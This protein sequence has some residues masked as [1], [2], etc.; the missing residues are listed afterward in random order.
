MRKLILFLFLFLNW[1]ANNHSAFGVS[2]Y[3]YPVEIIQPDG[4]KIILIQRGDEHVKWAQTVDGYSVMRNSKGIYE[5][6]V[7]SNANDMIP[8]G[9]P[10]KNESDR[11]LK[12]N[13]YLSKT[14]K[15]LGYSKSQVGMMKSISN[16]Y[17]KSAFKAFPTSGARKLVCLLIG[18]TDKAFTKTKTDFENLFNQ[19][20]YVADGA[21]GSVYDFYKENSYGK[22]DLTVTVAGPFTAAHDMA[23]Y[24]ANNA[25]GDDVN[26]GALVTEAINLANPFVNYADFDND[27]D[28][29]VDGIYV[30]YAGYGEE[31]AGVSANAIWAHSSAV[32]TVVLDGKSISVYSCSAELRG[33][34][35]SGITRIGVI[36][37]EFGHI[38]GAS[39]FYDTDYAVNGSYD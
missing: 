13:E 22:L 36:C 4:T 32:S 21:T 29:S 26:P 33:S 38:M 37:H 23:Y 31:V 11:N 25:N 18:F 35:G 39:D 15:G 1:F 19:I 20:G 12:D 14:A 2:A 34:S 6:A 24:G 27:N 28:G 7:L 30:I 17:L 16:M 9:I 10:A 5:F 3:P 8:S